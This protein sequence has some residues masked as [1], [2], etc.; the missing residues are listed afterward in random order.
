MSDEINKK[1]DTIIQLLQF[2][3]QNNISQRSITQPQIVD[4]D[5]QALLEMIKSPQWPEA[6]PSDLIC[7]DTEEDKQ[8]RAEGIIETFITTMPAKF[9]DLGCGEG[10]VVAAMSNRCQ[11]A[12]GYELIQQGTLNWE[13]PEGY[14]LTTQIEKIQDNAP[15]DAI[16]IYDVIDHIIGSQNNSQLAPIMAQA[17]QYLQADGKIY[18]RAHPWTGRHGGHLYKK[19]NKAFAHFFLTKEEI[20]TLG[21][22][23]ELIQKLLHPIGTYNFLFNKMG[24]KVLTKSEPKN[25]DPYF[26]QPIFQKRLAKIYKES[27]AKG[28][29]LEWGFEFCD[30]VLTH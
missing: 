17:K 25:I 15:Y 16:L 11:K 27:L 19:L 10:H 28:W 7:S 4:P 23:E 5:S 21:H 26:N 2:I 1:L 8:E 14:L 29:Q 3:A 24:L 9:L 30:Y 22:E 13:A 18:L 12:V 6:V 20:N